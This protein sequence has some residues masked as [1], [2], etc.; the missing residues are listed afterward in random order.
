MCQPS[1]QR[2]SLQR[3]SVCVYLEQSSVEVDQIAARFRGNCYDWFV[4]EELITQAFVFNQESFAE[5]FY[6]AVE[7]L[8]D[9]Y[10]VEFSIP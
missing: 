2:K 7:H 3:K 4:G 1:L 5:E 9:V 8:P 6:K 10:A